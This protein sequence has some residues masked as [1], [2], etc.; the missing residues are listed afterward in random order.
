MR[1]FHSKKRGGHF[2]KA[3]W[4]LALLMAVVLA[5]MMV[6]DPSPVSDRVVPPELSEPTEAEAVSFTPCEVLAPADSLERAQEIAATYGLELKS[7]AYGVAVFVADNPEEMVDL[8]SRMEEDGIPQLS[9][10]QR[11]Q[12]YE[13]GESGVRTALDTGLQWHHEEMDT[14]RAWDLSTGEG[15]LV[16][17]ID[18]G[19]DINHSAFAGR[20]SQQS[21]NSYTDQIGLN[22]VRDDYGHGTHVS[23]IIAASLSDAGGR[24]VSGVAPEAGL[25]V[26]KANIP[27]APNFFDELA[28]LRGINYA[29]ENGA[30]VINMSLGRDYFWGED[31]L[32]RSVIADAIANGVTMVCAAG[33][34]SNQH[35]GYPAAYPETIAVSATRQGY[36]FDSMYSGSNYGPEIDVA[37][38][39]GLVYSTANGGGYTTKSGTS[40]ASPNVAGVVALIKT[41]HP[42]YTP[43]QMRTVLRQTAQHAGE[44]VNQDERFGY[45]IVSAYAAVLEPGELCKVTYDFNDGAGSS[46]AVKAAPGSRL[47]KPADPGTD[48]Y[49]FDAWLIDGTGDAF[50]FAEP[51]DDDLDLYAQWTEAVPG[52]YAV[53]FPDRNFR[54]EV[55]R[56]LN[57]ATGGNRTNASMVTENDKAA[58][59]AVEELNLWQKN[60]SD[61]TGLQY[62]SGLRSLD[63]SYNRLV[64]LDISNNSVLE[65]LDCADN[66]LTA[67]DVSGNPQ[68]QGLYCQR[69]QLTTLDISNRASLESLWCNSNRLTTLDVS[70]CPALVELFCFYNR[71]T[72][73][74]L[75]NDTAL[76]Y[77]DCEDNNLTALNVSNC[78]AL[79]FLYCS[80]NQLTV[81]NI[82]TSPLLEYLTCDWNRLTSLDVSANPRLKSL[83]CEGN[84]LAGLAISANPA[85]EHLNCAWN[86]LASLDA[87]NHPALEYLNCE[88]NGLTILNVSGNPLLAILNCNFN[89]LTALNVSN[90]TAL[91]YLSCWGNALTSLDVSN[92]ARLRY[93]DCSENYMQSTDDVAGW[94]QRGLVLDETFF[95]HPQKD[96]GDLTTRVTSEI[97]TVKQSENMICAV[98]EMTRAGDFLNGLNEQGNNIFLQKNNITLAANEVVGTGTQLVI[99]NG[100]TVIRAYTLVVTGDLDGDGAVTVND[101]VLITSHILEKN[102]LGGAYAQA[103]LVDADNQITVNDLVL[104]TSHILGKQKIIAR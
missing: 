84:E 72:A 27:D 98:P 91:E 88:Y 77:L 44:L 6:P 14:A 89:Q 56:M 36:L 16:A 20:I 8:S 90:N 43:E 73:L 50:D 81:L 41:L 23:G 62:F 85:L 13:A 104:I 95:F 37:A 86:Q 18:T 103:A 19:I 26:I 83:T 57:S 100:S 5:V 87:S 4:L 21:Y 79:Y 15:V 25:L 69:N 55:L 3:K 31:E 75:S 39:G 71:L 51:V 40:M 29:V 101:L 82:S 48:G 17:V 63:C 64:T 42:E 99:M 68:L 1:K 93:L 59:A 30:D 49:V 58:L 38:P 10:N 11:Y 12:T 33:N 53:E 102:R 76:K 65:Y 7:Y 24:M 52:M 34:E 66:G 61:M 78:T 94:R 45:G 70:N 35:A 96:T 67:L 22:Y 28:L 80:N 97:F 60:I 46:F 32:E 47:I 9:L 74:N 2:K 54:S 92:N